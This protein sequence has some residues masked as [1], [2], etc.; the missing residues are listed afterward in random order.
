MSRQEL[1]ERL[2]GSLHEAVLDDT[3]WPETLRLIDEAFAPR[4][5]FLVTGD[6]N[7]SDDIDI[8]F[9][10]FCFHGQRREDLEQ[11]STAEQECTGVVVACPHSPWEGPAR[12]AARPPPG[13]RRPARGR[14]LWS[15]GASG[16]FGG[17]P[18]S[19][20]ALLEPVAFAVHLQ[21]VDM[22]GDA[23][24]QR[25]GEPLAP[26]PL[27]AKPAPQFGPIPAA[28]FPFPREP[29]QPRFET[30]L[31][32]PECILAFAAQDLADEI[33]AQSGHADDLLDRH[34]VAGHAPNRRVGLLA[35]LEALIQKPLGSRQRGRVDG[36]GTE[37]LSDIGHRTTD[38][39]KESLSAIVEQMPP[40]RDLHCVRK[41]PRN[42]PT[43][44]ASSDLIVF[45]PLR[46]SRVN[47]ELRDMDCS[48]ISSTCWRS[49]RSS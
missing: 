9:A 36:T 19:R 44:P 5:N 2:L 1:F 35:A 28:A 30:A 25:A 15:M 47:Q 21:N 6:G 13:W 32:Q 39:S 7:A 38:R 22:V 48:S 18:S 16:L 24:E 31:S 46:S 29:G 45:Q 27:C 43:V 41:S 26:K 49:E 34:T 4:G 17:G 42:T 23:V 11:L 20:P 14:D 40:V 8:F 3:L 33:A 37:C 10:R 12:G